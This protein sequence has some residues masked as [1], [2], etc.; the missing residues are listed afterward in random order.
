[1]IE[2]SGQRCVDLFPVCALNIAMVAFGLRV[3][4]SLLISFNFILSFPTE[5]KPW[6]LCWRVQ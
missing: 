3:K 2:A 6:H 5:Y 4:W 1:M